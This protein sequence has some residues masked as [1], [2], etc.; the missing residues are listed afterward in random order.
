[1]T[2]VREACPQMEQLAVRMKGIGKEF[3]RLENREEETRARKC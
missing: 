2:S 1:M 3:A